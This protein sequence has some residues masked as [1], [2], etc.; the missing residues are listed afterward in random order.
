MNTSFLFPG[1]L[2]LHLTALVLMAGTTLIDYIGYQTF[3]K[4]YEHEKEKSSGVLQFLN[5]FPR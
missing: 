4:F 1:F 3:W 2:I 5:R